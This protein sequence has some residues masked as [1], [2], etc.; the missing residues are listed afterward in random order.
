[1][2]AA[3]NEMHY[4]ALCALTYPMFLFTT[5]KAKA[6]IPMIVYKGL[7]QKLEVFEIEVE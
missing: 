4:E 1:M 6:C 2:N 3:I 7:I 5:S